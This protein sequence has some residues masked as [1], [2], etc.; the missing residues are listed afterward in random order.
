MQLKLI[1]NYTKI[2]IRCKTV[3]A[4][5]TKIQTKIIELSLEITFLFNKNHYRKY[6]ILKRKFANENESTAYI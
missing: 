4:I 1:P 5:K 3:A 6:E 2:Q